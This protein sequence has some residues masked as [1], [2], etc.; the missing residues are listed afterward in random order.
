MTSMRLAR[1]GRLTFAA[2]LL[3]GGCLMDGQTLRPRPV[4]EFPSRAVQSW[5]GAPQSWSALRGRVVLLDVWT[6]G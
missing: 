2:L 3:A 1:T 6:F 4:P 5:V